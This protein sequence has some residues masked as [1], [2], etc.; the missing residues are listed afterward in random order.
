MCLSIITS[1]Y[2]YEWWSTVIHGLENDK[3]AIGL[4][5]PQQV[6]TLGVAIWRDV[7]RRNSFVS[8]KNSCL[9][10]FWLLLS[11]IPINTFSSC[12]YS[13]YFIMSYLKKSSKLNFFHHIAISCITWLFFYQT[14]W[15][16]IVIKVEI[17]LPF[18]L[19]SR[20]SNRVFHG[21]IASSQIYYKTIRIAKDYLYH[22]FY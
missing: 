14:G 8:T 6:L 17:N 15:C 4:P 9:L 5:F 12:I 21:Y 10:F 13:L 7:M 20:F 3:I 18:R 22:F 16:R 2:V 1:C 19:Y 11:L